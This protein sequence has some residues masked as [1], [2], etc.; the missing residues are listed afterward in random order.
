[1]FSYSEI[2]QIEE[3]YNIRLPLKYKAVLFY[4][5]EKIIHIQQ[6]RFQVIDNIEPLSIYKIQSIMRV[7]ENDSCYDRD[8]FELNNRLM[9]VF[10]LTIFMPYKN[11][12]LASISYFIEPQGQEDC[13]VYAWIYN[14]VLNTNSIEKNSNS[15]EEWLCKIDYPLYL[16]FQIKKKLSNVLPWIN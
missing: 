10:F 2:R 8:E 7:G 3:F 11:E 1:M 14:E 12:Y 9:N 13:P 16:E 6:D 5:G 15:I 4:V